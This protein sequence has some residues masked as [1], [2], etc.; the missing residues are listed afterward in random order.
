MNVISCD[1]F[2]ILKPI[3]L[4]FNLV[5]INDIF[6]GKRRQKVISDFVTVKIRTSMEFSIS[7]DVMKNIYVCLYLMVLTF[8]NLFRLRS[9]KKYLMFSNQKHENSIKYNC[10]L[11][12]NI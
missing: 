2:D 9:E 4:L 3:S 7:N 12:G 6:N 11:Q 5:I 10:L 1:V 8:K